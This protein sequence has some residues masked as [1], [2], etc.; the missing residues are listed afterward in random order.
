M[1]KV[2]CPK[3]PNCGA[4]VSSDSERCEY[5]ASPVIIT[6]FSSALESFSRAIDGGVM[7]SEVFFWA[8]VCCLGGKK[9]FLAKREVIDKAEEYINAARVL[10]YRGIYAYF[11]AYVMNYQRILFYFTGKG[12]SL[13]LSVGGIMAAVGVL[14]LFAFK[15]NG[16]PVVL[17]DGVAISLY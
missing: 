11:V 17:G 10:E 9:A 4:P 14:M 6:S 8:G 3:C 7:N 12:S 2:L 16:D 13:L 15:H 5:C 1:V